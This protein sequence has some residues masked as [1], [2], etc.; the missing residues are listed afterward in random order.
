MP[1][2]LAY[3]DQTG[4]VSDPLQPEPSMCSPVHHRVEKRI[5]WIPERTWKR[6]V[7]ASRG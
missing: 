6:P 7:E 2:A 1:L 3:A 4:H 5:E